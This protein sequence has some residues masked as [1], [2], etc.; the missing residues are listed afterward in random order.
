MWRRAENHTQRT[1]HFLPFLK[2]TE[3]RP[4]LEE[5]I[6][7]SPVYSGRMAPLETMERKSRKMMDNKAN[8]R[9]WDCIKWLWNAS[10]NYR[11]PILLRGV[12]GLL[13]AGVSLFRYGYAKA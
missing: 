13:H 11:S 8:M 12:I 7:P 10:V 2:R 5:I 3:E 9:I 1:V 6:T 4:A